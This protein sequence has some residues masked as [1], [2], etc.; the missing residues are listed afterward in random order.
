ML[1]KVLVVNDDQKSLQQTKKEL[2][3][4]LEKGYGV[5]FQLRDTEDGK[6]RVEISMR[7]TP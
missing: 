1:K 2:T 5:A 4:A 6:I 3:K 7:V